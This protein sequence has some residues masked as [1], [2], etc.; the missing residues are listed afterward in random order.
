MFYCLLALSNLNE[1][2]K[3]VEYKANPTRLDMYVIFTK[4]KKDTIYRLGMHPT[5]MKRLNR[6]GDTAQVIGS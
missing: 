2:R 6:R 1:S 3:H 5:M 4:L